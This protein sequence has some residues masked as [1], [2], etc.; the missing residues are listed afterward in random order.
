MC[1]DCVRLPRLD[2][3]FPPGFRPNERYFCATVYET[4]YKAVYLTVTLIAYVGSDRWGTICMYV[5]G[6]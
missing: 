4:V 2:C 5:G 1:L 3:P 6:L